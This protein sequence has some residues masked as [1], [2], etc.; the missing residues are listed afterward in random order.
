MTILREVWVDRK[1]GLGTGGMIARGAL[2]AFALVCGIGSS[3]SAQGF[4]PSEPTD[5]RRHALVAM[6]V[7]QRDQPWV[8]QSPQLAS[9]NWWG[10]VPVVD[11]S[12]LNGSSLKGA[13][14]QNGDAVP[15]SESAQ[16]KE[17]RNSGFLDFNAYPYTDVPSDNTITIN[18]LANLNHGFQY[19]SLTNFGNDPTLGELGS[20]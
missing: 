5:P 13:A 18:A 20:V 16:D 19:F 15:A 11:K 2:L 6:P 3:G 12:V 8:S 14:A 7:G 17:H 1:C 10:E 4:L 9:A